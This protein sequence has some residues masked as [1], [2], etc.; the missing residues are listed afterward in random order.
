MVDRNEPAASRACSLSPSRDRRYME[1]H[2]H[3]KNSLTSRRALQN[4]DGTVVCS[5]TAPTNGDPPDTTSK[6]KNL[7]PRASCS[8][9][10]S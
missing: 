2:S 1:L 4:R 8:L 5:I 3:R 7:R 6:T 9:L 10:Y